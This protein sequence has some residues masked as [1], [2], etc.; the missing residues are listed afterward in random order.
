M[1]EHTGA[2]IFS[3]YVIRMQR[4]PNYSL[5]QAKPLLINSSMAINYN[6]Y[7]NKHVIPS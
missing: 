7:N 6:I 5:N 4:K 2:S 3:L 1:C